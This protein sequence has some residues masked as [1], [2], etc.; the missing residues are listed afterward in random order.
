MNELYKFA[1]VSDCHIGAQKY[2]EL[3]KIE[4]DVF[5]QCLDRCIAENVD[6][7][8][9]AG[10]LFHSNLPN[11]ASV[12]EAV[13]KM[14]KVKEN[15]IPIY[16]NYG[17]HDYS[18]NETSI[19]DLL[20]SAGLITK[21]V[22]GRVDNGKLNLKFF[23]DPKTG[24]KICGI[25]ARKMGLEENYFK[26]LDRE[27]L[28][29]EDGFKIFV[30]HSAI[31]EFKPEFLADM[32]SIPISL[33]PKGFDYYA[34]GHIHKRSINEYMGYGKI[35]YPGSLFGSYS[36]DFE[37]NANGEKRG[38]YIVDFDIE[39]RNIGFIETPACE[40]NYI[41]Y[42]ASGKN[43]IQVQSELLERLKSENVTDKI[44]LLKIKG[45]LSGGKTSDIDSKLIRN[46]LTKNGAIHVSINRHGLIS[47][48]HK[49][50]QIMENNIPKIE[51]KL[52]EENIGKIKV[53]NKELKSEKGVKF[54]NE[55]L[56]VLRDQQKPN[57]KKGDYERRII[58]NAV[59]T[60]KINDESENK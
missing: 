50:I 23:K 38:F 49:K 2:P 26:V 59:D 53:T 14:R 8:I 6:F 7:I 5:N 1:H 42:D 33:F 35:V 44:V 29:Y 17:S 19:I 27:S 55:L 11:M 28:E 10:D 40:Y 57:E 16:V 18:P 39:I 47:K 34:G 36:K 31:S 25:S 45:E 41:K 24:A 4:L 58:S 21:I 30:F 37:I 43:S 46:L 32:D 54:A 20:N 13:E 52:F 48:E 60:L 51:N 22:Q 3:K 15:G 56:N 12:K 9:I